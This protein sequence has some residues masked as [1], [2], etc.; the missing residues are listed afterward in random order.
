VEDQKVIQLILQGQKDQYAILMDRYFNELFSFVYNLIGQYQE[1]EDLTQEIFFKTYQSLPKYNKEK[2]S[3]RTWL[4][5]VASN[6]TINYLKS[7]KY[8][9]ITSN[10]LDLSYLKSETDIEKEIIKQEQMNQIITAMKNVLSEKHQKILALHYFSNF[11][12]KEISEV[13]NIPDK[14]IYKALKTSIEKIQKEVS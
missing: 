2:A 14:T 9:K 7:S 12:V 5:R 13:M 10:E 6:H 1:T 11:T 4:Y 8:R 3:F